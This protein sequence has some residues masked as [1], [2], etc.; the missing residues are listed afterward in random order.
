MVQ[1]AEDYP[2]VFGDFVQKPCRVNKLPF[3][4]L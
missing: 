4:A 1:C 2:L 3:R